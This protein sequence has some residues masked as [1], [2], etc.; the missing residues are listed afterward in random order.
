[1]LKI[2]SN[3][4]KS[5]IWLIVY[6]FLILKLNFYVKIAITSRQSAGV[7]NIFISPQRLETGD[8]N[9]I[10]FTFNLLQT[11]HI[12][13]ITKTSLSSSEEW[14][15]SNKLLLL[16]DFTV[17]SNDE[18]C[19]HISIFFFFKKTQQATDLLDFYK[20]QKLIKNN[21]KKQDLYKIQTIKININNRRI[22]ERL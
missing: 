19:F 16:V 12:K 3:A 14:C 5:T 22:N 4:G 11:K 9:N 1:M 8:L 20:I 7:K 21:I 2:L 17:F 15:F 18:S 6:A 13:I 10:K